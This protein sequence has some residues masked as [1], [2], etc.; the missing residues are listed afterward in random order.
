MVDQEVRYL[1][2]NAKNSALMLNGVLENVEFIGFH[3]TS[4][5]KVGAQFHVH[6][7]R[8][9]WDNYL[10]IERAWADL[11]VIYRN[12]SASEKTVLGRGVYGRYKKRDYIVDNAPISHR[13]RR[14]FL[15][16]YISKYI[17]IPS[18]KFSV[19]KWQYVNL[20]IFI[21]L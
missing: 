9:H 17:V 7:N 19:T 2:T 12:Q 21:Y 14:Y 10:R 11:M 4:K 13:A 20:S 18:E 6:L 3:R 16:I 15:S 1:I 5:G 8:P